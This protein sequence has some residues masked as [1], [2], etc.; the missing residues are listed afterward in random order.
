MEDGGLLAR[1]ITFSVLLFFGIV[2]RCGVGVMTIIRG[3][4]SQNLEAE[5]ASFIPSTC[6]VTK[7]GDQKQIPNSDLVVGDIL[8]LKEGDHVPVDCLLI[9]ANFLLFVNEQQVNGSPFNAHKSVADSSNLMQNPDPFLFKGSVIAEGEA[10]ALV[11][12]VGANVQP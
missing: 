1:G 9:H 2:Y 5:F 10:K 12:A 4:T 11:L 3:N 6:I 7:S 8:N